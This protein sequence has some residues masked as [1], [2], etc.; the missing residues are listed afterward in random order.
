MLGEDAK[1]VES[2]IKKADESRERIIINLDGYRNSRTNLDEEEARE[3]VS[4][5]EMC[6]GTAEK[7]RAQFNQAL[8]GKGRKITFANSCLEN[9]SI[10]RQTMSESQLINDVNKA[11]SATME[12]MRPLSYISYKELLELENKKIFQK[13]IIG[14]EDIDFSNLIKAVGNSD[15]V[16]R[17]LEYFE[18]SGELCPFCQQIVPQEIA[19]MIHSFFN[20]QYDR[21]VKSLK[22]AYI[23]Y[24][25]LTVDISNLVYSII[26]EKVTGYDYSNI[27]TLFDTLTSKIE[28][29]N[30]MISSKQEELS[31]IIHIE[32]IYSI[33]KQ[34]NDCIACIN[35]C[36]DDNNQIL[37]HKKTERERVENEVICYIANSILRTVITEY[38]KKVDSF[39]KGKE[40]IDSKISKAEKELK[41][42]ETR[43]RELRSS[44][45]SIERTVKF[46]QETM[47]SIGF[48]NFKI[49]A[50]EDG[51]GFRIN[52]LDGSCVEDTLSE[53]EFGFISF[54]YFFYLIIGNASTDFNNRKKVVVIDDPI[55][56]LDSN[57]LFYITGLIDQII[58][59]YLMKNDKAEQLIILTHNTYFLK[60]V[61]SIVKGLEVSKI[62]YFLLEKNNTGSVITEVTSKQFE[63]TY[64]TLW[65]I[66]YQ[67]EP[68]NTQIVLNAMRRI[69]EDFIFHY[70]GR[71]KYELCSELPPEYQTLYR[72]LLAITNAGSHDI[73]D[74]YSFCSCGTDIDGYRRV[75]QEVFY[76]T[77]FKRHFDK[78]YESIVG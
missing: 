30:Q 24:S 31:K 38:K 21:D 47:N 25:H 78:M 35:K 75:F 71:D 3:L 48:S 72:A 53:G 11:Y 43:I 33:V 55:S 17:G 44:V 14:N 37:K 74:D 36:I 51:K 2:E 73:P 39:K 15:W 1:N 56:S 46:M 40:S 65:R 26:Q 34:I 42:T 4:F 54:L 64:D 66:I 76:I 23:E 58:R 20:D 6:W 62:K 68:S 8:G 16:Y 50:T 7:Q 49:A 61:I 45:S 29:N 13:V 22:E 41:E 9:F 60:Q 27:S 70:G 52:R 28:S 59:N 18:K 63:S 32:S 12:E 5:Q 57:C 19:E 10:D 77:G 67:S 69:I